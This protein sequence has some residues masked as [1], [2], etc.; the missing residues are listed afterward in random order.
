[1]ARYNNAIFSAAE[2]LDVFVN[3]FA[4]LSEAYVSDVEQGFLKFLHFI[5]KIRF[6]DVW[7]HLLDARVSRIH[8]ELIGM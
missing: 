8:C 7:I 3:S 4:E 2:Q 6:W 5:T 1:M